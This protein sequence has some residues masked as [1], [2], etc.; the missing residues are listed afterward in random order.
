M[1]TR[2]SDSAASRGSNRTRGRALYL[3]A[4]PLLQLAASCSALHPLPGGGLTGATR[5][6][7]GDARVSLRDGTELVLSEAT[8]TPDSIVGLGGATRTRLAVPRSD[9]AAVDTRVTNSFSTFVAG[10]FAAVAGLFLFFRM[11]SA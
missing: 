10:G 5:E 8:I 9:V 2:L 3:C 6:W 7:L 11:G 4:L 1:R